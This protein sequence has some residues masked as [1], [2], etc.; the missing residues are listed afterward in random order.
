VNDIPRGI[1]NQNPGN[2]RHGETIWQ[3]QSQYQ[4]DPAYVTF[5]DPIYGIRAIAR[6]LMTYSKDGLNTVSQIIGR[7]APSSENDTDAYVESVA[8]ALGV[9]A[10]TPLSLTSVLPDL[11]KAIITH[12]NGEQPYTE[13]QI[14]TGIQ[15][16]EEDA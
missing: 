15:L 5:T 1:R 12:E 8:K 13:T 2:I 10:N 3:G 16:A 4:D 9:G 7:W 11:V 14:E 6:I